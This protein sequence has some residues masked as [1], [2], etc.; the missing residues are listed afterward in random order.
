MSR[1]RDISE[2]V[3]GMML[4]SPVLR[5]QFVKERRK[6]RHQSSK[7]PLSHMTRVS[8]ELIDAGGFDS[9]QN[10]WQRPTIGSHAE[11]TYFDPNP[12]ARWAPA[13]KRALA[14]NMKE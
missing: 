8:R 11:P 9:S 7:A 14:K 6:F 3:D 13:F 5:D 2:A 10:P 4:K 1:A 12:Q